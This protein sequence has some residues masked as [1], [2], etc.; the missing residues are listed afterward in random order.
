M[1]IQL[2]DLHLREIWGKTRRGVLYGLI[3]LAF[4]LLQNVVFSHITI[5]GVH[6]MFLPALV[7]AVALFEG[8]QTGGRFGLAAGILCDLFTSTQT[9]LFTWLFPLMGFAVGF[10]ADFYLNRRLFTYCVLSILALAISAFAQMFGLLFYK[11]ENSFSLWLTAVVQTVW[12]IPFIFPA[13]YICKILPRKS[14]GQI[15]SPY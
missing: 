4:L 7:I 13:Y 10:L 12:S 6:S 15:P 11:G 9:V 14:G 1:K 8:G 5:F 3:L 2:S